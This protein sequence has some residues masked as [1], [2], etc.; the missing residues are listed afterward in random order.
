MSRWL[1]IGPGYRG[2][3]ISGFETLDIVKRD[4]VDHVWDAS[5]GLPFDDGTFDLIYASH[6][7]EHI[8]WQKTEQA[9]REW[10]RILK[11]GGWLEIWVPDALKICRAFV[12]A[13]KGK[14]KLIKGNKKALYNEHARGDPCRWL[15]GRV[16]SFT[17]ADHDDTHK[18]LFSRRYLK[19]LL[20][21]AGLV[22]V[23]E[24]KREEIRGRDYGWVNMGVKGKKPYGGGGYGPREP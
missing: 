1:E 20:K 21:S 10:V 8:S 2:E 4:N 22:E 14:Y 16:F 12:E 9:L 13:E 17:G 3:R 5:E 7:L 15:N 11:S 19:D 23:T 24:L 18:A 6:I